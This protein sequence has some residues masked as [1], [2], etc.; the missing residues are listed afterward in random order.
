MKKRWKIFW[1]VCGSMFLIGIICC[2][3]SWGMGTTLT[4]IAHQFPHGI[5]WVSEDKTYGD[6]DDDDDDR[7][8]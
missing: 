8:R 5:S 1:I 7:Y 4:D 3:V 2:S 6:P